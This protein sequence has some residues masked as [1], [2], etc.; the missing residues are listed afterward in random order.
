MEESKNLMAKCRRERRPGVDSPHARKWLESVTNLKTALLTAGIGL[1]GIGVVGACSLTFLTGHLSGS[2]V[3]LTGRTMD[4]AP[5]LS[6]ILDSS[7]TIS[8]RGL[9]RDGNTTDGSLANP[10]KWTSKYGSLTVE[11][12]TAA[13]VNEKGLSVD[14]LVLDGATYASPDKT[15]PSL[16]YAKLGTYLLDN[17]AT[18]SEAL[19]LV[20]Q[21]RVVGEK[22]NGV[23]LG[24][25]MAIRD[26]SNDSAII[27]FVNGGTEKS[28]KSKTV[29]Y[30]GREY[31]VM[32]NEPS[33]D[34]QLKYYKKFSN[35]KKQLPGDFNALDRF[36]RLELLN[37][38]LLAGSSPWENVSNVFLLLDSVQTAPGTVDYSKKESGTMWPTV[39]T[40]VMD[41]D[42]M[43]FYMKLAQYPNTI[44]VDL[45]KIDFKTLT[46]T[47]TLDPRSFSL[48]G[49]VSGNFQWR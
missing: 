19:A 47:G 29:V 23:E 10:A 27:E 49:E 5:E 7:L 21:V 3:H 34:E 16:S 40:S 15:T 24:L 22:V 41:F 8:P 26:A 45:K 35:G 2:E 37:K 31:N 13:G 6:A 17:A 4:L 38:T 48:E 42:N 39:W 33:Y 30:H 1:L 20:S 25:H 44:W 43:T 46:K 32:T 18:V 9:H 11:K 12:Y 36:V 14:Y 28:P